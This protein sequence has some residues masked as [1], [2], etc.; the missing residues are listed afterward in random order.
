MPPTWNADTARRAGFGNW[1]DA[2]EAERTAH[3][4]TLAAL[5]EAKWAATQAGEKAKT[6]GA[7]CNLD[8]A[9]FKERIAELETELNEWRH[10]YGCD[11]PH[12][13]HVGTGT[14]L[15][16]EQARA[17]RAEAENAKLK[18]ESDPSNGDCIMLCRSML[19][20]I[21]IERTFFDD[22][23]QAVIDDNARLKLSIDDERETALRQASA[24]AGLLLDSY[25][26]RTE[27]ICAVQDGIRRA[28]P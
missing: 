10:A 17:N 19:A 12:D 2:L 13:T 4:S 3:Q 7:I 20:E 5:E 15:G 16:L 27:I 18:A 11:S 28:K 23:V 1:V 21:G 26:V 6:M 25:G 22:C 8:G 9:R 14:A 24:A